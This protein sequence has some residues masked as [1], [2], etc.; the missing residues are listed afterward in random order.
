DLLPARESSLVLVPTLS[1]VAPPRTRVEALVPAAPNFGA[2]F[3]GSVLMSGP[4]PNDFLLI[5]AEADSERGTDA[6]HGPIPLSAL[7][8]LNAFQDVLPKRVGVAGTLLP[9]ASSVR[10][11]ESADP[12]AEGKVSTETQGGDWTLLLMKLLTVV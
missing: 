10:R 9:E 1:A 7:L 11:A 2:S 8:D 5:P 4:D 12:R 3:S 6:R